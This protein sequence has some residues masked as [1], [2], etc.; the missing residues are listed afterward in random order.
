MGISISKNTYDIVNNIKNKLNKKMIK[1]NEIPDSITKIINNGLKFYNVS[2]YKNI[3]LFPIE[4]RLY[5]R[6]PPIKIFKYNNK[7]KLGILM[8]D[9]AFSHHFFSGA[10]IISGYKCANFINKMINP[11]YN[12]GYKP[13]IV[14]KYKTYITNLRKKKWTKYA[15]DL[16]IPFEE[17]EQLVK[18]ISRE[19]LEKIANKNNIPYS[20]VSKTELG[21]I[22]GCKN[23]ENC[24]GNLFAKA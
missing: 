11:V 2:D 23:I 9:T 1:I 3:D 24:K 18:N 10:G 5:H 21:F 22:L 15:S 20:K 17:I 13:G 14:N 19:K 16:V 7:R 8:G 4:I 12:S 6:E